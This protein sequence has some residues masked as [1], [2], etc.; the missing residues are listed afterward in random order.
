[1]KEFQRHDISL[2]RPSLRG[3]QKKRLATKINKK[4]PVPTQPLRPFPPSGSKQQQPNNKEARKLI[5]K[6]ARTWWGIEPFCHLGGTKTKGAK[7]TPKNNN[8]SAQDLPSFHF[9]RKRQMCLQPPADNN[10]SC[11]LL[12]LRSS[13][14]FSFDSECRPC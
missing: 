10:K 6:P 11:V 7:S 14:F 5:Q 1:M 4:F 9:I 8:N 3:T 12:P 13:P 2:Q